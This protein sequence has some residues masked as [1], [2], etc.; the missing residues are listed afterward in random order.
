MGC[1]SV[2]H[3]A[4]FPRTQQIVEDTGHALAAELD[5][6]LADHASR[7]AQRA[8]TISSRLASLEAEAAVLAQ[9]SDRHAALSS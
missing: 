5:D 4:L 9:T 1:D 8:E 6:F 7:V 2:H 3:M